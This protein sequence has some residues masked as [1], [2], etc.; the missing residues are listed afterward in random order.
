[1]IE[2]NSRTNTRG[3]YHIFKAIASLKMKKFCQFYKKN[4]PIRMTGEF[5]SIFIPK[6]WRLFS[7]KLRSLQV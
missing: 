4:S 7:A 1:M 6:L 5:S 3:L 2:V